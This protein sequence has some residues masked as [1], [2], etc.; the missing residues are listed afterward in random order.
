[1]SDFSGMPGMKVDISMGGYT[2]R[3]EAA[4]VQA[5]KER[6]Q[7]EQARAAAEELRASNE[8][9][10]QQNEA[11]RVQAEKERVQT[12]TSRV[13]EFARMKRESENAAGTANLAAKR[14][15]DS[16]DSANQASSS[17]AAAAQSANAAAKSATDAANLAS[18]T[19]GTV[20]KVV[21]KFNDPAVT[22]ETLPPG[23]AA[24]A[25]WIVSDGAPTLGLG[26]P[27]GD[28]GMTAYEYAVA[29]G[30]TGTEAEFQ[31]L[32]TATQANADAAKQALSDLL[33]IVGTDIAIL[34]GGKIP[35][36]QIPATATQEIYEVSSADELTALVAQRG[37][38]A[39][40]VEAVNGERTIT[41]TWQLL[42]DDAANRDN[43]V[44]WGTSYA[45]QAGYAFTATDAQNAVTINGH[46]LVQMDS[47]SFETA[48]KDPNTYYLIY[49]KEAS[50]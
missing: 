20:E 29:G 5:E 37:D 12:E 31:M 7:A 21:D 25:E 40:L 23:S 34:V 46:R 33:K 17:A 42:H 13:G 16:A 26:L 2:V 27:R 6:V 11:G 48:V 50:V 41:K 36:S 1:M 43:W 32:Q 38:L 22:V 3:D 39:E 45:V 14:A 44:I 28:T 49:D 9:T 19:A 4:R 47:T 10:R 35:M 30:Y 15:T 24:A 18:S 8:S